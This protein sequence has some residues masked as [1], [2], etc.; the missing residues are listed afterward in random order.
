MGGYSGILY[1][2]LYFFDFLESEQVKIDHDSVL[3]SI[4]ATIQKCISEGFVQWPKGG[5]ERNSDGELVDSYHG[6]SGWIPVF[7]HRLIQDRIFNLPEKAED[8]IKYEAEG[9]AEFKDKAEGEAEIEAEYVTEVEAKDEV[10]DE[11]KQEN[12]SK[13]CST[14]DGFSIASQLG[15]CIWHRGLTAK[16]LGLSHGIAGNGLALLTLCHAEGGVGYMGMW[17]ERA[18]CFAEFGIDNYDLL[19]D[20]QQSQISL[21]DDPSGFALFLAVLENPKLFGHISTLPDFTF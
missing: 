20:T 15:E 19:K 1:F 17:Y 13:E 10:E 8:E 21:F 18:K 9:E 16:G 3:E 12:T 14:L 4:H 7:R 6:A 11:C 5:S 2:I